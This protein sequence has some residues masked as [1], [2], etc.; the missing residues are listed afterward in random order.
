MK[1][2]KG[3]ALGFVGFFLFVSLL[4][5]GFLFTLNVTIL[6]PDFII[7]EVGKLDITEVLR[8][9]IK[10]ELPDLDRNYV[11]AL[12]STLVQEKTW[13]NQQTKQIVNTSYS[14]LS[15]DTDLLQFDISLGEVKQNLTN[16]LVSSILQSPPQEYQR[17]VPQDKEV[18]LLN[19]K[20]QIQDAIPSNY[21]LEI[22]AGTI[23]ADGMNVLQKAREVIGYFKTAFIFLICFVVLM[24]LLIIL[25]ERRVRG[26]FRVLGIV[27][28]ID[29]VLGILTYFILKLEIPALMQ[30]AG[31][32]AQIAS[33]LPVVIN[34]FLSPWGLFSLIVLL[35]GGICLTASFLIKEELAAV[36]SLPPISNP[37]G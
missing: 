16:N 13:I 14:Y 8:T 3:M 25:I 6:N 28:L 11:S 30:P 34:D 24:I 23:G 27:L 7:T 2:L 5:L 12:D 15:G 36:S 26:I 4:V 10:D 19:L 21:T 1:F 33:W 18:Y 29:G 31:M 20:Q 37:S 9:Y 22:N 32:P 35:A 17:L